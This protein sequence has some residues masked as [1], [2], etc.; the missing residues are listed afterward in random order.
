MYFY[1]FRWVSR[2]TFPEISGIL[3]RRSDRI[4][5]VEGKVNGGWYLWFYIF[6]T[7][8]NILAH[9]FSLLPVLHNTTFTNHAFLLCTIH[10]RI[11]ETIHWYNEVLYCSRALLNIARLL[12]SVYS[13]N[14]LNERLHMYPRHVWNT[15]EFR[16]IYH[17]CHPCQKKRVISVKSNIIFQIYSSSIY[18][19][20]WRHHNCRVHCSSD[21]VVTRRLDNCHIMLLFLQ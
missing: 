17:L 7:S 20:V 13:L 9:L 3:K 18:E 1:H 19:T 21:N 6:G 2:F 15:I 10:L 11:P 12:F 4:T 5:Q 16:S 14:M 8:K